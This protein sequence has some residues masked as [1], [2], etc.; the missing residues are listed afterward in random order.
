[1]LRNRHGIGVTLNNLG[2]L[3]EADGDLE[4]A[5]LLFSHAERMLRDLQ[6]AHLTVPAA[7][8]QRLA[9]PLGALRWSA[10]RSAAE[11]GGW[12]EVVGRA[13]TER[14]S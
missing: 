6:S 9:E 4:T 10:L 1:M 2:E 5:V 14:R 13:P 7:G 11:S 8:L 3:S 12:E